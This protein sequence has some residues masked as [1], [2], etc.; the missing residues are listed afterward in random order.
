[1]KLSKSMKLSKLLKKCFRDRDFKDSLPFSNFSYSQTGEDCII[2]FIFEVL[3][4]KK[5]SYIDIGAHHPFKLNNTAR[6]YLNGSN[7]INIEPNPEFHNLLKEQRSRDV[8]LNIG[9]A[10]KKGCLKYFMLSA[11]TLNTFSEQEANNYVERWNGK[12]LKTIDI[13]VDTINNVINEHFDGIFPDLMG[14]DVEGLEMEILESIDFSKSIPKVICLETIEYTET[15]LAKTN[16]DTVQYL[17]SK[18]YYKFANTHINTILVLK[19]LW[20][21]RTK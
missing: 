5:P 9:I 13:P 6:F 20:E 10:S 2:S 19:K 18:G 14:L 21:N 16:N 17:E 15:G 12:I 7:G 4:I 8:N 1:M 11:N 3:D